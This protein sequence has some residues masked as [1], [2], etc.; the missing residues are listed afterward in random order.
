MGQGTVKNSTELTNRDINNTQEITRD[1]V[2][3]LLNGSVTVDN[4]LLTESGRAQ[5]I[6]EQKDLPQN[7]KIIAGSTATGGLILGSGIVGLLDEKGS[8]QDATTLTKNNANIAYDAEMAANLQLI[9]DGISNNIVDN[10][11]LINEYNDQL[12]KGTSIKNTDVSLVEGLFN[13]NYLKADATTNITNKTDIYLDKDAQKNTVNLVTHED[14]HQAGFGEKSAN[15]LGWMGET[16]FNVN[17]WV[18]SSNIDTAKTQ[19]QN[20][21]KVEVAGV[22]DAQAQL[23]LL[24]ANEQKHLEQIA[25]GD[26]FENHLSLSEKTNYAILKGKY[27]NQCANKQSIDCTN[28][29]KQI[30]KL[31]EK[32]RTIAKSETDYFSEDATFGGGKKIVTSYKPNDLVHCV[33]SSSSVCVVTN[34]I[35]SNGEYILQPANKQQVESYNKNE[36]MNVEKLKA[37]GQEA[38]MAGCSSVGVSSFVCQIY[39]AAGKPYPITGETPTNTERVLLGTGA[40]L[41]ATGVGLATSRVISSS[42]SVAAEK[43]EKIAET[44]A[45]ATEA[46]VTGSVAT[47]INVANGRTASTPLRSTGEPVSAGFNHVLDGHFDVAIAKNRS[48]FSIKP[49]EL[50]VLLQDKKIV[51]SRVVEIPGGQYVRIVDTGKVIGTT[52]LKEGGQ[53]TRFIKVFTDSKGNLI[54]TYPVKGN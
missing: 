40:V 16:A 22:N 18:N 44:S 7:S 5:I 10:Q 53:P 37:L 52:S 15:A 42:R 35:A 13:E 26:Q 17:S 29:A 54:T 2:T 4:R 3:G 47:R 46:A 51:S 36:E 41:Q 25:G 12:T 23:N 38:Y 8:V 30:V 14:A 45:K 1:Q 34:K 48:V 33:V 24:K 6:Q 39:H 28:L 21:P 43:V 27:E 32:G 9:Q 50:K 19:I 49:D 20:I 11:K 31:V